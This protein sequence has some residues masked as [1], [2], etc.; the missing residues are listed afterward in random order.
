VH[1]EAMRVL[2][3]WAQAPQPRHCERSEAI[4]ATSS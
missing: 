3:G 2:K 1:A 4:S